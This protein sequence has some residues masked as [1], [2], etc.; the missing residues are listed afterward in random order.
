MYERMRA[1]ID[2]EE[3]YED[4]LNTIYNRSDTCRAYLDKYPDS[5]LDIM[6]GIRT[7][8]YKKID[9][10]LAEALASNQKVL[11]YP[12]TELHEG[13]EVFHYMLVAPEVTHVQLEDTVFS[14]PLTPARTQAL[15]EKA[16]DLMK[17]RINGVPGKDNASVVVCLR[18]YLKKFPEETLHVMQIL[19]LFDGTYDH[20][21]L[22]YTFLY[23][24]ILDHK[25]Q[26]GNK[27]VRFRFDPDRGKMGMYVY[28]LIEVK[29]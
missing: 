4:W 25:Q 28:D 27:K 17:H 13:N 8:R 12:P 3:G 18:P 15:E 20:T 6:V 5:L 19:E 10:I 2:Y 21:E 14:Q 1:L 29:G 24:I 22:F 16:N 11:F 9:D 26:A 7:I 23:E